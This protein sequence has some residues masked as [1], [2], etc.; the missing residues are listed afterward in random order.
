MYPISV[1]LHFFAHLFDQSACYCSFSHFSTNQHAILQFFCL[2]L[3]ANNTIQ[4]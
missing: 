4:H 2:W 1:W 3:Q